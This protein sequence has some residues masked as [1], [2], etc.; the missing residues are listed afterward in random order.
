M[1][2]LAHVIT[3][4]DLRIYA[5]LS[6]DSAEK[7]TEKSGNYISQKLFGREC[8]YLVSQSYVNWE[9]VSKEI[10]AETALTAIFTANPAIDDDG[11]IIRIEK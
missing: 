6:R 1:T 10:D 5:T 11:D 2:S 8:Y 9:I 7:F 4:D 3:S